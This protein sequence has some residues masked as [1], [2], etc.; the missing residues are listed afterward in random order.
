MALLLDQQSGL[1]RG[2]YLSIYLLP[3]IIAP[4]AGAIMFRQLFEPSGILRW[5]YQ[6]IFQ[7]V[8]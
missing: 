6:E 1:P 5:L 2:F 3:F 4:I 7:E 8:Y